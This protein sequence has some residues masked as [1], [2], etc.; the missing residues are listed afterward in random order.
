VEIKKIREGMRPDTLP[1]EMNVFAFPT[2]A[3]AAPSFVLS[4]IRKLAKVDEAKAAVN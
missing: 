3:W 2:L 1:V 4:Y